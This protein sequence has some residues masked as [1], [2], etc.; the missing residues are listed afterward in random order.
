MNKELF[1]KIVYGVREY[2]NYF[3]A[4]QDCMGL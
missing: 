1:L 2:D 3:V 4:K